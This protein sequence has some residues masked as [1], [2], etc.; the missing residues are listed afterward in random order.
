MTYKI[1]DVYK[2]MKKLIKEEN[3]KS[4]DGLVE[5][6]AEEIVNKNGFPNASGSTYYVPE[7]EMEDLLTKSKEQI[8]S[9][10]ASKLRDPANIILW[11]RKLPGKLDRNIKQIENYLAKFAREIEIKHDS[12]R[13]F[14]Y[15]AKRI[16]AIEAEGDPR[17]Y[18]IEDEYL[19]NNLK[20]LID[21]VIEY[22]DSIHSSHRLNFLIGNGIKRKSSRIETSGRTNTTSFLN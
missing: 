14:R 7:S 16:V 13:V 2:A 9:E 21:Q 20:T 12:H 15:H 18:P 6:I 5:R 8:E 19:I 17:A 1:N 22:S 3:I 10:L 4:E 11:A